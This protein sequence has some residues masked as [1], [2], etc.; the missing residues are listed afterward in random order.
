M[1]LSLYRTFRPKTFSDMIG[2]A[3]LVRTLKNQCSAGRIGHAYLF[4]GSRGTGKTSAA[5]IMAMAIN[6]Q[7]RQN[8]DPCLACPACQSILKEQT[9][10]VFEMDAA[11]NSRVEE[12]RD[13]LEKVQY[14]PQQA[15][16]K[17]YIIDEVHM[18]S[19][20]A[21]NAL[22]KTL[23][24][25]P[26][27]MVFILA[28]T[29]PQKL[30]ATILSRC[31]RYDFG[32]IQAEDI[33]T[34]LRM[35]LN[36]GQTAEEGALSYI[37]QAAEGS[38]RDAWSLMDM[39]LTDE[40]PLTEEGVRAALGAAK[41]E[42]LFAFADALID[43]NAKQALEI[44]GDIFAGGLDV[45]VFLKDMARH[46]RLLISAKLNIQTNDLNMAPYQAQAERA[47]LPQL[48][49]L[50]DLCMQK[51]AEA[52]YAQSQ[53]NMLDVFALLAC[54]QGEAQAPLA[55]LDRMDK[56]EQALADLAAHPPAVKKPEENKVP[57][58]A[59][60]REAEAA[61]PKKTKPASPAPAEGDPASQWNKALKDIQVSMPMQF[62]FIKDGRFGGYRDET[63]T[64]YFPKHLDFYITMLMREN[65]RAD[66]EQVLTRHMGKPTRF[67]A[68]AEDEESKLDA[69]DSV[70][71]SDID[72]L[73]ALVGREN[74]IVQ[75]SPS[76][77]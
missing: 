19:N 5:R 24:E 18:L 20:A 23:E 49:C 3:A 40:A 11:S 65:S 12:I 51:E 32:R 69:Q 68:K 30:P 57:K 1:H 77:D 73:S 55:L 41:K 62:G 56:M 54:Q 76:R 72:L 35:A 46:L 75:D 59:P 66:I 16:Y 39:C 64:L 34:R 27:Y 17:V 25:P 61:P 71:Q 6:C 48:T 10:D 4:C 58:A 26:G 74:L 21:F 33:M 2:Q 8:G 70:R 63:F 45:Q 15:Q 42:T 53:K 52:R 7:N 60:P 50:M 37:A 31:Q 44:A 9:L 43:R 67:V 28:T 38:M 22:L 14:P 13:L 29:E 47:T 36:D